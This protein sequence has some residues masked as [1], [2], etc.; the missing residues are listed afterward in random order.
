V[1]VKQWRVREERYRLVRI[2]PSTKKDDVPDT[3]I[4]EKVGKDATGG[5]RWDYVD[6]WNK[7]TSGRWTELVLAMGLME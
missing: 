2:G 1:Q 5:D 7:D 3:F 6:K 4:L